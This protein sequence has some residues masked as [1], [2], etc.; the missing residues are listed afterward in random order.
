MQKSKQSKANNPASTKMKLT[1]AAAAAFALTLAPT[2]TS[3]W[4]CPCGYAGPQQCWDSSGNLLCDVNDMVWGWETRRRLLEGGNSSTAGNSSSAS[5]GAPPLAMAPG[6]WQAVANST[7]ERFR[8]R[9]ASSALANATSVSANGTVT[10]SRQLLSSWNCPSGYKGPGECDN[11]GDCDFSA[12]IAGTD[13]ATGATLAVDA[14]DAWSG[15]CFPFDDNYK[16]CFR[17]N[18]GFTECDWWECSCSTCSSCMTWTW[19]GDCSFCQPCDWCHP[20]PAPS[21]I[22]N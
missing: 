10:K 9:N 5:A 16:K 15:W 14:S 22:L 19:F 20:S 17:M 21:P 13:S 11:D 1:V 4:N 2:E 3:A 12:G 8:P 6:E 7:L 18:T